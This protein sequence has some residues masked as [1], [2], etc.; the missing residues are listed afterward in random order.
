MTS[1]E[2][3]DG[4]EPL[5][6]SSSCL[7]GDF[8][9]DEPLVIQCRLGN[10]EEMKVMGLLDTDATG[11]AFIDE[12]TAREVCEK[13]QISPQRLTR[14]KPV[15]GFDGKRGKDITHAIYPTLTIQ[16]H[17]ETVAPLLITTLGQHK[18][19]LGKPWMRKHGVVIDMAL[20]KIIFWPGHCSH[21]GA[22]KPLQKQETTKTPKTTEPRKVM[23]ILTRT[24][25]EKTEQK[26][27]EKT[28][29]EQSMQSNVVADKAVVRLTERLTDFPSTETVDGHS[30]E[31]KP[32]EMAMIGA[33]AYR[34]LS[35]RKDVEL[36]SISLK[37]IEYQ[38]N[39]EDRPPTDPKTVVPPEYH[40]FLDVFSKAAS[41][42]LAP[43]RPL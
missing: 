38:L 23:K 29:P 3:A 41:D 42:T 37:D 32:I 17:K 10:S 30:T 6:I 36:F 20:D 25:E 43:H 4:G 9:T 16:H 18:M 14:P 15:K 26:E 24:Q 31:D 21:P 22:P 11:H 1:T 34:L 13:L 12:A 39:K 35:R 5:L 7:P 33:A 8:F 19:I 2:G 28:K 27:P 40:E